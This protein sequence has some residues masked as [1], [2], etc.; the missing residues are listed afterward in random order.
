LPNR[1][2]VLGGGASGLAAAWKLADR[3]V[4]VDVIEA[5]PQVGGLAATIPVDGYRLDVGP[6]S[7]FSDDEAVL[8]AVLDLFD[9][10]MPRRPRSVRLRMDGKKLAYPLDAADLVRKLGAMTGLRCFASYAVERVR[11]PYR[12]RGAEDSDLSVEQWGAR[13]FGRH[14]FELFFRPYTEQ[15]WNM[16][17]AALSHDVI[18]TSKKMSFFKT[19]RLL[20]M[21]KLDGADLSLA[22]RE[23]LPSWYPENG[24]GAICERIAATIRQSGGRIHLNRPVVGIA[25]RRGAECVVRT[26]TPE[27]EVME[28]PCD[29]VV[30][31]IPL[32][33]LPGLLS[34]AAPNGVTE[35]A[36]RLD[37]LSLVVLYLVTNKDPILECQYEYSLGNA[38]NRISETNKFSPFTSPEGENLLGIEF[39]CRYGD[40]VWQSTE[41]QLFEQCIDPL[42]KEGVVM[43]HE[44]RDLLVV[45]AR[46]VYPL[47]ALGY[48][49]PLRTILDYVASLGNVRVVGRAGSFE[50]LDADQ[51]FKKGFA[52]ADEI[53]RT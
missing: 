17:C 16:P 45:K 3:G 20:L 31:T 33:E 34:P 38:Y 7:F 27:D 9:G 53:T 47:F 28:F 5:A 18:P 23:L 13:H 50:Y 26:R 40:S 44:V 35:A 25:R 8:G 32:N 41:E 6:H 30:S 37:F 46:H 52:L 29:F 51:C 48:R 19:L 24:F 1:V 42:R 2:V 4:A 15:F 36:N 49:E 21:P 11:P 12:G 39:S 22:E 14:L 10:H 43:G